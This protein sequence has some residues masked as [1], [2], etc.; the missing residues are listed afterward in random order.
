MQK[1][2]VI[3]IFNVIFS[4]SKQQSKNKAVATTVQAST[5][6]VPAASAAVA[7]VA[8][9]TNGSQPDYSAQWAEYYRSIGKIKEAEAIETQMK[10]KVIF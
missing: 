2:I 6:P 8:G 10:M 7:S 3:L 5:A 9:T 1:K 4:V